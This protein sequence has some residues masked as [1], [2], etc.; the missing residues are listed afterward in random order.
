M[1]VAR[2]Q[3]ERRRIWTIAVVAVALWVVEGIPIVLGHHSF[4]NQTFA[5]FRPWDPSTYP[6]WWPL[7]GGKLPAFLSPAL[8][9]AA[10]WEDLLFEGVLCMAI[11]VIAFGLFRRK[12]A[13]R[14]SVSFGVAGTFGMCAV[15]GLLFLPARTQPAAPLALTAKQLGS[16]WSGSDGYPPIQLTDVGPGR[17]TVRVSYE[18]SSGQPSSRTEISLHALPEPGMSVSHWLS[19]R[20]PTDA[21]ELTVVPQTPDYQAGVVSTQLIQIPGSS[22]TQTSTVQISTKVQSLLALSIHVGK[23]TT[24]TAIRFVIS[25]IGS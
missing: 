13:G 10:T 19:V 22:S 15:L 7:V 18:I 6:G 20:H 3:E 9:L 14:S 23:R 11:A 24:F 17:Y 8:G 16:A 2:F 21:A 25:K 4:Y 1:F 5:P 12:V